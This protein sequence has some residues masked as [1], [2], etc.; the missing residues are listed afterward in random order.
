[1]RSEAHLARRS[2]APSQWCSLTHSHPRTLW[3]GVLRSAARDAIDRVFDRP[4]WVSDFFP[5][6]DAVEV[7]DAQNMRTL[8]Y[9]MVQQL[10]CSAARMVH[11][12][13]SSTFVAGVCRWRE[14]ML[15]SGFERSDFGGGGRR[16]EEPDMC[17]KLSRSARLGYRL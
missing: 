12:E 5:Y 16:H 14:L 6:W 1:M 15:F 2:V 10:V 7:L 8:A 4:L 13:E 11:G 3:I 17:G 9:D